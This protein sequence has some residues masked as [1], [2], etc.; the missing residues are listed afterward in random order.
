MR[1]GHGIEA[2]AP[3]HVTELEVDRHHIR[4]SPADQLEQLC[5]AVGHAHDLDVRE[6][7]QSTAEAFENQSVAISDQDLH[8]D[9][10]PCAL[11]LDLA[12]HPCPAQATFREAERRGN[13]PL[14]HETFMHMNDLAAADIAGTAPASPR[15]ARRGVPRRPTTLVRTGVR[16]AASVGLTVTVLI[17]ATNVVA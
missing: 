2:A 4:P 15:P 11:R 14:A 17:S 6:A 16:A 8:W 12:G 5:T 13:R 9:V 3:V 1:A 7:V 10:P